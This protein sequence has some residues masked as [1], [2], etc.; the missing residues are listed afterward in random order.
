MLEYVPMCD[1]TFV[2]TGILGVIFFFLRN[3]HEAFRLLS[4]KCVQ[5]SITFGALAFVLRIA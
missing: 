3:Q 4:I 5:T 1:F 2:V